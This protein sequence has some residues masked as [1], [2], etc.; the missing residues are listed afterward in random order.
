MAG[1]V[2]DET[3]IS[4]LG[5]SGGIQSTKMGALRP[6][7]ALGPLL[8]AG[9]EGDILMASPTAHVVPHVRGREKGVD[10]PKT[11]HIG[12]AAQQLLGQGSAA[13]FNAGDV[14]EFHGGSCLR[15]F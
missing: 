1:N 11:Q 15:S 13:V 14:D 6:E 12:M 8:A 3:E 9:A 2:F 5:R 10:L 4:F 7:G